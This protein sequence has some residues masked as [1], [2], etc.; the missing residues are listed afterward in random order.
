[1]DVILV[2]GRDLLRP[3]HLL[4][5]LLVVG[6]DLAVLRRRE[7]LLRGRQHRLAARRALAA[8]DA[9][10]VLVAGVTALRGL[11]ADQVGIVAVAVGLG[12]PVGLVALAAVLL[13]LAEAAVLAAALA[14]LPGALLALAAA[15]APREVLVLLL[16]AV[17]AE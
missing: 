15:G 8:V 13:A 17:L 10:D 3:H 9:G 14:R 1:L 16:L 4:D 5:L 11:G 2:A 6:V 12:R 7:A